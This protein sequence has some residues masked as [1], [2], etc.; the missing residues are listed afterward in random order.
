[1][2]NFLSQ[3]MDLFGNKGFASALNGLGAVGN[4]FNGRDQLKLNQQQMK[5]N[6]RRS[7]ILFNNDQEDRKA[8]QNI[9][10]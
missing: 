1:M 6:E 4:Y 3:L 9:D 8:L 5:N 10:F 7:N 2:T